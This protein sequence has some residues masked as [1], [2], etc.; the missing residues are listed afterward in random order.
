MKKSKLGEISLDEVMVSVSGVMP[1]KRNVLVPLEPSMI[2]LYRQLGSGSSRQAKTT[3]PNAE[4]SHLQRL[5]T[6]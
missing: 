5:A 2:E 3:A 1:T 6:V 4:F